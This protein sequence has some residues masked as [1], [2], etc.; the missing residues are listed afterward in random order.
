VR[1]G[2]NVDVLGLASQEMIPDPTAREKGFVAMLSQLHH[3]PLGGSSHISPGTPVMQ[4]SCEL[5]NG[6][7]AAFAERPRVDKG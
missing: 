5:G 3:N 6:R 2:G 1:T 4:R 7:S